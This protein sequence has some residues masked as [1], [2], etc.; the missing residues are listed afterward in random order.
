MKRRALLAAGLVALA[1]A[2]LAVGHSLRKPLADGRRVPL[3]ARLATALTRLAAKMGRSEAQVRLADAY[4]QGRGIELDPGKAIQWYRRAAEQGHIAAQF[5]LG[6]ILYTGRGTAA[7]PP[8]GV[9]WW[10][11]AAEAGHFDAQYR[12]ADVHS[13]GL[14]VPLSPAKARGWWRRM[15]EGGHVAAR[16]DLAWALSSGWG[17]PRDQAEAV[18]IWTA[19]AAQGDIES[20]FQ[21]GSAYAAGDGVPEDRTRA[22]QLWR[23]ACDPGQRWTPDCWHALCRAYAR[24]EGTARDPVAASRWCRR[25][26]GD[27]LIHGSAG[28]AKALDDPQGSAPH[29]IRMARTA[30]K[31]LEARSLLQDLMPELEATAGRGDPEAQYQMGVASISGLGAQRNARLAVTWLERAASQGH[32]AAAQQLAAIERNLSRQARPTR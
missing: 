16:Q 1:V 6:E 17:G 11:K 22:V 3:S 12:L 30:Q 5:A 13:R 8:Q 26:A 32:E 4:S 23:K 10:E 14:G 21:L 7:S 9:E 29:A 2:A 18:S 15:A 20:T 31:S 25:I 19:L 24:G 28:D 27:Y